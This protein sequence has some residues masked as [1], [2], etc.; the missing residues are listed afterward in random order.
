MKKQI[1]T[2]LKIWE[3]YIKSK[4]INLNKILNKK[5]RLNGLIHIYKHKVEHDIEPIQRITSDS[6]LAKKQFRKLPSII[7]KKTD[8]KNTTIE[9][10]TNRPKF[11]LE[12]EKIKMI[13]TKEALLKRNLKKKE[14]AKL[15][16]ESNRLL[17]ENFMI[18]KDLIM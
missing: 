3:R 15:V 16:K 4:S 18:L 11:T 14:E 17:K 13:K 9:R 5:K 6:P 10:T 12:E 2:N 1:L 8:L 7:E